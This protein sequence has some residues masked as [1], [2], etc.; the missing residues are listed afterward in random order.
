LLIFFK[1]NDLE[2]KQ[3][4]DFANLEKKLQAAKEQ[5]SKDISSLKEQHS[6]DISS[7]KEQHSKDISSLKE[8]H[9]KDQKGHFKVNLEE[10]KKI[11]KFVNLGHYCYIT[12]G[13]YEEWGRK[14]AVIGCWFFSKKF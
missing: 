12:T 13:E 10:V 9:S 8:Q 11:F 6:K 7:L 2:S 1:I 4:K 14:Y 3:K 5:H